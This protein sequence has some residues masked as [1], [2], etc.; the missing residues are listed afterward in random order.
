MRYTS[1]G[2]NIDGALDPTMQDIILGTGC[3]ELARELRIPTKLS[4]DILG[5]TAPSTAVVPS[6]VLPTGTVLRTTHVY[7]TGY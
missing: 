4:N 5:A 2:L 1:I 7:D 6:A 3:L